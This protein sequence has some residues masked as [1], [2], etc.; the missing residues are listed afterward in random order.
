[1]RRL[2]PEVPVLVRTQDDARIK[3]CRMPGATDVVPETFESKSHVVSHVL[4]LL[5]VPAARGAYAGRDPQET[6]TRC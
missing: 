6:A 2:R 1:L 4:M 3:S 5:H